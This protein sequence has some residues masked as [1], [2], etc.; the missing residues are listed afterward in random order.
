MGEKVALITG[1]GVR[2]GRA[3]ALQLAQDGYQVALHYRGS[4]P[5]VEG[6][7]FQA[8]L[9]Q[10]GECERLAQE[11]MARFGRL[12]VLVNNAAI[13]FPTPTLAECE[14]HWDEFMNLNL[15]A[16][17]RLVR[18]F[19]QTLRA[20][21]G[22]VVNIVDIYALRPTPKHI[23]YVVSKG[24][25]WTLTQALALQLAPDVRVNAV[26]PGAALPPVG[27]PPPPE[28]K[29]YDHIPLGRLGCAEDIAQ[30]VSYVV[31][32]PYLTG[33]MLNVDGGRLL[34]I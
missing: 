30:A 20:Q 19:E 29:R 23:P 28:G 9:S 7:L 15:R 27:Y 17:F 13:F 16:P 5:D 18:Q 3:T 4:K 6:E 10:A 11:V 12:D 22:C 31:S 2:L 21:Q 33:H 24:A 32:A 8:D 25:L 26:S 14:E 34:R 1:A